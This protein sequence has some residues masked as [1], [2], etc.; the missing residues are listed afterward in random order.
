MIEGVYIEIFKSLTR[1]MRSGEFLAQEWPFL[2]KKGEKLTQKSTLKKQS[3][4]QFS[5]K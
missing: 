1:K 3:E 2:T 5:L 4:I